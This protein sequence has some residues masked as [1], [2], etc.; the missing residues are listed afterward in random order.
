GEEKSVQNCERLL[1]DLRRRSATISP[2][3]L[4]RISSTRPIAVESLCDWET[5]QTSLAK[6]EKVTLKSLSD[7]ENWDVISA[8]GAKKTFPGV[9]FLIPPPDPDAIDKVELLGNELADIKKRRAALAASLKNHKSDV[10]KV[11]QSA[12]VS[13]APPDPKVATLSLQLDQ[14]DTELANTEE[15]MLSQLRTPVSRSDPAGDLAKK[16]K[17]QE[18]AAE[19]LKALEQQIQTAQADLQPLLSTD[20]SSTS[21]GLP[22]KLS[23]A[24]SKYDILAAVVDLYNKKA[25]A[26]LSLE[27]QIQKM[28]SLVSGFE[29]NL[30]EDD[31]ISDIPNAIQIHTEAIQRQQRSVGGVQEDMIKLNQDLETTEKLCSSLQQGYQEYCPDIQRQRKDVKQLEGRYANVT[32]Q[33][34]EREILLQEAS[35]KYQEFQSL[36]KY[37]N[38]T[39][40]NLPKNQINISD[41]LSEV[42][43]KQSS[44][45]RVMKGLRQ[46]EDDIGRVTVLS[47]DL[48]ILLNVYEANAHKYNSTL[49]DVGMTLPKRV[50]MLT[51][52]DAIGKEEK[53]LVN[54][55]AEATAENIQRQRHMVLARNL[56]CQ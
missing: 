45:E 44:Q 52:A 51:L 12:P 55:Y 19:A 50:Q 20:P 24:S 31:L 54:R 23:A 21:S 26:S 47:Q 56:I 4:R 10:P 8:D 39:L 3:K 43:A 14:L 30:S 53:Q 32:N 33:L 42:T 40:E 16:L 25:N 9:C 18:Q 17:A 27:G 48:Q 15:S 1:T 11:Q 28:D 2:L 6:G 29:R 22:L 36:C 5:D 49:E 46:K 7:N 41:G 37:L 38:S 35:S 34:K 13:S